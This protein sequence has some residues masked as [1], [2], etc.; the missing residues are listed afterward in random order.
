MT[1]DGSHDTPGPR[2]S[3]PGPP[4][5]DTRAGLKTRD[6]RAIG[7]R[8]R[9]GIEVSKQ[10]YSGS[11]AEDLWYRLDAVDFMNQAMLLDWR[12]SEPPV[13]A[14]AAEA[15]AMAIPIGAMP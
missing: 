6:R 2:A 8:V 14:D 15:A 11:A 3:E 4:P 9:R 13:P 1:T 12:R 5:R 7:R 10:K